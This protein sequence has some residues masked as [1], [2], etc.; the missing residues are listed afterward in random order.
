[1]NRNNIERKKNNFKMERKK[2][3]DQR[4]FPD[5]KEYKNDFF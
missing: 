1:M 4:F 3:F 5:R 2:Y